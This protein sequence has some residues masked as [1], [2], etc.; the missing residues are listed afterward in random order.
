MNIRR[1]G[2]APAVIFRELI[3]AHSDGI[4]FF[5]V[6]R[7]Q[8]RGRRPPRRP[9]ALLFYSQRRKSHHNICAFKDSFAAVRIRARH[10]GYQKG[11]RDPAF[12]IEYFFARSRCIGYT[13]ICFAVTDISVTEVCSSPQIGLNVREQTFSEIPGRRC[14][15]IQIIRCKSFFRRGTHVIRIYNVPAVVR[16]PIEF[17]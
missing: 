3:C 14:K 17:V 13:A 1:A 4:S 5:T 9:T 12:L 6:S 8:H 7:A 10:R 16:I 2:F 15:L 11:R